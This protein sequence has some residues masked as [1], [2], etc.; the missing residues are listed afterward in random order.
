M[1]IP[2]GSELALPATQVEE[3]LRTI[4]KGLRAFQMY[5]PNNPMYQRAELAIREA[6]VPIWS[7]TQQLSLA[8]VETDIVWADHVVYR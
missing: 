1:T 3:L 6:F 5:L 4:V 7:S 2:S 8:I